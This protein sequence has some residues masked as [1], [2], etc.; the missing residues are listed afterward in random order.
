MFLEA[1]GAWQL[2]LHIRNNQSSSFPQ[3]TE[4]TNH[5]L[6]ESKKRN[7]NR[8]QLANVFHSLGFSSFVLPYERYKKLCRNTQIDPS[9]AFGLHNYSDSDGATLQNRFWGSH[10]VSWTPDQD[11]PRPT[12]FADMIRNSFAHGQTTFPKIGLPNRDISMCNSRDGV[13]INFEIIMATEHFTI[14]IAQSLQNF[15]RNVVDGGHHEPLST[16]LHI[17][18]QYIQPCA[19]ALG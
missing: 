1:T 7:L 12:W 13:D 4:Q 15:I 18:S 19:A 9:S 5:Y 8:S 11:P 14:L 17:M 2:A 6:E 3:I 10:A 16:Y